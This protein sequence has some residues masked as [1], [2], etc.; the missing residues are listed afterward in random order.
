MYYKIN[1]STHKT[2]TPQP[3]C[4]VSSLLLLSLCK[5]YYP[6]PHFL[7]P[8]AYCP[9][10]FFLFYC[11]HTF[12]YAPCFTFFL[13][14]ALIVFCALLVLYSPCFILIRLIHSSCFM[15]L[16]SQIRLFL[17]PFLLPQPQLGT[18]LLLRFLISLGIK[19]YSLELFKSLNEIIIVTNITF[20][21]PVSSMGLHHPMKYSTNIIN[22]QSLILIFLCVPFPHGSSALF[23]IFIHLLVVKMF[24]LKYNYGQYM[25]SKDHSHNFSFTETSTILNNIP[26]VKRPFSQQHSHIICFPNKLNLTTTPIKYEKM[27]QWGKWG[28]HY[29]IEQRRNFLVCQYLPAFIQKPTK[30][31]QTFDLKIF[32]FRCLSI[33]SL[34]L[35]Q[36]LSIILSVD[37]FW[38]YLYSLLKDIW[39]KIQFPLYTKKPSRRIRNLIK[40]LFVGMRWIN[41]FP[42]ISKEKIAFM[43]KEIR[44]SKFEENLKTI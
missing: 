3:F 29:V 42:T 8:G 11:S 23:S 18:S 36:A 12:S 32:I 33:F 7:Y 34:D 37:T 26:Y 30:H 39:A 38:V 20:C 19:K 35:F 10:E 4:P 27:N 43:M 13:F 40:G 5:Y 17:P 25:K 22:D 21:K 14:Y 15:S 44:T 2:T 24:H 16:C 6:M 31:R 41:I 1:P 9:L 28:K